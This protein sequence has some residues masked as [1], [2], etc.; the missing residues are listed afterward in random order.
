MR[1]FQTKLV[2][3]LLKLPEKNETPGVKE[4]LV[5]PKMSYKCFEC[6]YSTK[7]YRN[8][9]RHYVKHVK[10]W[11]A[12]MSPEDK[13]E[14]LEERKPIV[15]VRAKNGI[16][17]V[18]VCAVCHKLGHCNRD[19]VTNFVETKILVD[20]KEKVQ[21]VSKAQVFHD[22][23]VGCNGLFETVKY[24]FD[25][26]PKPKVKKPKGKPRG[27]TVAKAPIVLHAR[28]QE[29]E[30][31]PVAPVAPAPKGGVQEDP[32]AIVKRQIARAYPTLFEAYFYET[33]EEE[34]EEEVEE[35]RER[36][37]AQRAMTVDQMIA[38][39]AKEFQT[40][41]DRLI[42]ARKTAKQIALNE[43]KANEESYKQEIK[44]LQDAVVRKNDELEECAL[45]LRA[46]T[47]DLRL[48]R[49]ELSE[50]SENADVEILKSENEN[51]K[52]KIADM[53]Q[54]YDAV[55]VRCGK[56]EKVVDLLGTMGFSEQIEALWK[57]V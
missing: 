50:I 33:D 15:Y 12:K 56:L 16:M 9:I 24:L 37:A 43:F 52:S 42:T 14:A 26:S 48:A 19:E 46:T 3:F 11:A 13:K 41:C 47:K 38:M 23:H 21:R 27:W 44:E 2:S 51:L 34:D 57:V 4:L 39:T 7:V 45:A 25:G 32:M 20:D 8:C 31:A 17:K 6:D 29:A 5:Q 10:D 54:A 55:E 30:V 40:S 53:D 28:I 35:C 22:E 36:R 49:L 1:T 18:A